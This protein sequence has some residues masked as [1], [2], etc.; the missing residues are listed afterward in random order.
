MRIAIIGGGMTGLVL[1]YLLSKRH[2]VT[3]YERETQLGGLATHHD[4][5]SFFWDRFYHVILPSDRHLI[6]FLSEIG[7]GDQLRWRATRTGYFTDG[8]FYSLSNALEQLKF[9]LIGPIGKLRLAFA[10]FYCVAISNWR[11]LEK[12]TVEDWLRRLCGNRVYER[13]WRPLLNAKLGEHHRRV[14][15]V[16]IWTYVKRLFSARDPSTQKEQLGHVSGGYKAVF[17]RLDSLI[18]SHGGVIRNG[19]TVSRIAPTASDKLQ[20]EC[21]DTQDAFDKVIFTCPVDVLGRVTSSQ[22]V[23]VEKP[24]KQVEYLGV[25]CYVLVTRRPITPFYVLNIGDERIPFTGVIGM[26]NLVSTEETRGLHLTYFPKYVHSEDP[27]L[28]APEEQLKETF[29][30]GVRLL[31]PDLKQEEIHA[32][33]VNRAVK[34]QPL[35]VLNYSTIVPKVET[36]HPGFFVLNTAQFAN[37]TLNNDEVVRAVREFLAK[38]AAEF[39]TAADTQPEIGRRASASVGVN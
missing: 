26:S 9:P 25:I 29:F 2:K 13:F 24:G 27:L 6:A 4:Y 12:I 18:R 22:L 32:L 38:F 7:L 10:I 17:E 30:A 33:H 20:V 23:R 31:F 14:S 28:R 8:R 16:F 39:E 37:N 1:A 36:A 5:G 19:V 21:A 15:A 34:V 3:L 35:Q 11:R